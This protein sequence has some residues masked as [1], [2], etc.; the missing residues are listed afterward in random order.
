MTAV[1][2]AMRMLQHHFSGAN[3]LIDSLRPYNGSIDV[4]VLAEIS[5]AVDLL[6]CEAER[7]VI[8]PVSALA[9]VF[10]LTNTVRR[11]ALDDDSMLVRNG[12]ISVEDKATL[13][14]WVT[15]TEDSYRRLWGILEERQPL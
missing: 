4:N 1:N 10:Y 13:A 11:W 9:H 2:D 15:E 12:R 6:R 14:K 5:N 3:G 8:V 7:G